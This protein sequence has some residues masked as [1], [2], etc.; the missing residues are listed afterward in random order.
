MAHAGIK[1]VW[2][3]GIITTLLGLFFEGGDDD[4]DRYLQDMLLVEGDGAGAAAWNYGMG[5]VLNGIPGHVAGVDL[6]K[7]DRDAQPVVPGP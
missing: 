1:G 4:V 6:T 7:P 5:M 2:G 3:Y